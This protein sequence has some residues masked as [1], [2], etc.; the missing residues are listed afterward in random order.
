MPTIGPVLGNILKDDYDKIFCS[1]LIKKFRDLPSPKEEFCR[2]CDRLSF[3]IP[4]ALRGF[5]SCANKK[6]DCSWAKKCQVDKFC[7]LSAFKDH[8]AA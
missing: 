5:Y 2:D 6:S 3:C 7:D 8:Y 1:E 4:C